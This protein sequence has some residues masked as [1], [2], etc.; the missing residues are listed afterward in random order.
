MAVDLRKEITHH[1]RVAGWG[2]IGGTGAGV[3]AAGSAAS[4]EQDETG[5][6][7]ACR[8]DSAFAEHSVSLTDRASEDKEYEYG[9][10]ISRTCFSAA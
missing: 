4:A 7:E 9:S 3:G 2:V 1:D 10:F 6:E 5:P 8:N